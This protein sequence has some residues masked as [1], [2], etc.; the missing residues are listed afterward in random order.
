MSVSSPAPQGV[1][2]SWGGGG[3][4]AL[5]FGDP[6]PAEEQLSCPHWLGLTGRGQD[7]PRVHARVVHRAGSRR[8]VPARGVRCAAW[9]ALVGALLTGGLAEAFSVDL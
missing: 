7:V 9:A 4:A 8:L 5:L 1:P 6:P 2:A 3:A